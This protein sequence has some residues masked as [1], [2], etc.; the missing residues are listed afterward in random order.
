[1]MSRYDD[2]DQHPL[3]YERELEQCEYEHRSPFEAEQH[4]HR[5]PIFVYLVTVGTLL[6]VLAAMLLL[7]GCVSVRTIPEKHPP[8]NRL[9]AS[10]SRCP[11]DTDGQTLE[12]D[13]TVAFSQRAYLLASGELCRP[14]PAPT[15][16]VAQ[17]STMPISKDSP[18]RRNLHDGH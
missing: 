13:L 5:H 12:R 4:Q 18:H 15:L 14:N 3:E 1:M 10:A 8:D 16:S 2:D 17:V 7:S 9:P 6:L 11:P